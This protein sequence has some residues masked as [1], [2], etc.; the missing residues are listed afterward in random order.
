MPISSKSPTG[1]SRQNQ[2][3]NEI[4]GDEI[5]ERNNNYVEIIRERKQAKTVMGFEGGPV[6]TP[7]TT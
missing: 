6:S 3:R 2:L 5:I 4:T 7:T 1:I